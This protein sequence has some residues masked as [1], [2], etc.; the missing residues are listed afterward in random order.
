MFHETMR[1]S[2]LI[3]NKF[4]PSDIM[5]RKLRDLEFAILFDLIIRSAL[6]SRS[7]VAPKFNSR[8]RNGE[9]HGYDIAKDDEG[10]IKFSCPRRHRCLIMSCK[11]PDRKG[12]QKDNNHITRRIELPIPLACHSSEIQMSDHH[13]NSDC[14]NLGNV[15]DCHVLFLVYYS[16]KLWM[17]FNNDI[18]TG[19]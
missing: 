11:K 1:W 5:N 15:N 2:L 10:R 16:P 12:K 9:G 8:L 19:N 7:A 4:R 13:K 17:W 14:T 18:R 3:E 6:N